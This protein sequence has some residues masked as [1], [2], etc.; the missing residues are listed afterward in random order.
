MY[1]ISI[2]NSPSLGVGVGGLAL[3]CAVNT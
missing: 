2:A 1:L 3:F